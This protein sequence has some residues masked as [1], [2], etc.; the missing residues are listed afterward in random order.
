[1]KTHEEFQN[2]I[3]LYYVLRKMQKKGAIAITRS[4]TEGILRKFPKVI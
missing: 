1:V 4:K 2:K 3:G